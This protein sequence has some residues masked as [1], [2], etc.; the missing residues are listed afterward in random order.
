MRL[1]NDTA[2][3]WLCCILLLSDLAE[4]RY[5]YYSLI[6]LRISTAAADSDCTSILDSVAHLQIAH[7][8]KSLIIR[9]SHSVVISRCNITRHTRSD[10]CALQAP[11]RRF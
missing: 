3:H 2:D 6:L 8:A 10:K 1:H 5:W 9:K 4:Y 7:T 11:E